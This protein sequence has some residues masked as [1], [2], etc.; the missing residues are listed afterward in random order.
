MK[1]MIRGF[2]IFETRKT[3]LEDNTPNLPPIYKL[4]YST[5]EIGKGKLKIPG[6]YLEKIG[7]VA[8]LLDQ[9]IACDVD[10][11]IYDFL[12]IAES[13]IFIHNTYD[14]NDKV[15]DSFYPIAECNSNKTLLVSIDEV[16]RDKIFIENTNLFANGERYKLLANNIFEFIP[17]ISYV[18]L[19]K[20]GYGIMNYHQLFKEWND[21][22]WRVKA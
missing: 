12:S 8:G 21:D 10:F 6:V 7:Q 15:L 18:E 2:D 19:D 14:S 13:E 17:K 5:F 1:N 3:F 20:I 9:K 22:N 16:N 11:V 4:F